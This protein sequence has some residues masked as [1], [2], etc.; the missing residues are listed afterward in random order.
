MEAVCGVSGR[1][2]VSVSEDTKAAAVLNDFEA[3]VA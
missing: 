2:R 1:K 3:G